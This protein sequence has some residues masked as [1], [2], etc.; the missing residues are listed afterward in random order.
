MNE[1]YPF[2]SA[3]IGVSLSGSVPT[4]E[5]SSA[6]GGVRLMQFTLWREGIEQPLWSIVADNPPQEYVPGADE[7]HPGTDREVLEAMFRQ[8]LGRMSSGEGSRAVHR[9]RYGDL[10]PGFL[11][12]RPSGECPPEL[13]DGDYFASCGG[14]YSGTTVFKI[15]AVEQ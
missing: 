1:Q 3:T 9:L 13:T 14:E 8:S 4:F 7:P 10:P 2:K 6:Q 11:Q 15:G 5:F 12:Q